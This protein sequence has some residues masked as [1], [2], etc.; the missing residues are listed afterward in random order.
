MTGRWFWSE[1]LKEYMKYW[2]QPEGGINVI[3]SYKGISFKLK[4]VWCCYSEELRKKQ[5]K[6]SQVKK[7]K[8]NKKKIKTGDLVLVS[9]LHFLG[10]FQFVK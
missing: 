3:M 7:T 1:H 10:S 2:V 5:S 8:D 6:K 9:Q 4:V